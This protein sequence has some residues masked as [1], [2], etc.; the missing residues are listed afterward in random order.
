MILDLQ[1][2]QA[3]CVAGAAPRLSNKLE[4][5]RL[6]PQEHLAIEQGTGMN[7]ENSHPNFSIRRSRRGVYSG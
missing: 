5:E 6:E 7:P 4:A 2:D 3:G 1:I